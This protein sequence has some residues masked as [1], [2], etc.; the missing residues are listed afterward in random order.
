M[1][2]EA[3]NLTQKIKQLDKRIKQFRANDERILAEG[4][5]R[6]NSYMPMAPKAEREREKLLKRLRQLEERQGRIFYEDPNEIAPVEEAAGPDEETGTGKI[7]LQDRADQI[8]EWTSPPTPNAPKR[9]PTKPPT[10]KVS[11]R[12]I[13]SGRP[14]ITPASTKPITRSN[15]RL[16][17]PSWDGVGGLMLALGAITLGMCGFLYAAIMGLI[18]TMW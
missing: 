14:S 15:G 13:P 4:G 8:N 17:E 1:S 6:A 7:K 16:P 10:A 3:I 9:A 2:E 18:P 12:N 5:A 11:Q